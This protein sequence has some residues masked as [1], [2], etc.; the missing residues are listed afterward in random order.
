MEITT[1]VVA[2]IMGEVYFEPVIHAKV[3]ITYLKLGKSRKYLSYTEQL[4]EVTQGFSPDRTRGIDW[5][6]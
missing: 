6:H 3:I 4:Q 2:D 1:H 5:A